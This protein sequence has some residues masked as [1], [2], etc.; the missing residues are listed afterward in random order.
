[1]TWAAPLAAATARYLDMA[2][3]G[4]DEAIDTLDKRKGGR[5]N[6]KADLILSAWIKA[7][8]PTNGKAA[9]CEISPFASGESE[10]NPVFLVNSRTAFSRRSG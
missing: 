5:F 4:R 7:L 6:R 3:W 2:R 1:M 9:D 8:L 10:E